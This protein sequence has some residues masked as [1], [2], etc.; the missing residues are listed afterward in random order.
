MTSWLEGK[1]KAK[2]AKGFQGKLTTG[3]L[4]RGVATGVDDR[5][6]DITDTITTY[7]FTGIRETWSARYLAQSGIPTNDVSILILQGSLKPATVITRE[8]DVDQ[9][10]YLSK[11][12]YKWYK[13]REVL[14]VDPAEA[15]ARLQCYEV[16]AP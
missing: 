7:T 13:I 15:S 14:E 5:G 11:P 16:P 9:L 4:R 10:V 3:V 12:W 8:T 2:I 1:L 6:N